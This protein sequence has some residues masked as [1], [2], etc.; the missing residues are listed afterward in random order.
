[1]TEDNKKN[2]MSWLQGRIQDFTVRG[3]RHG[4]LKVIPFRGASEESFLGTFLKSRSSER[5]FPAL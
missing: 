2:I 4:P 1:M 3:S 5:G